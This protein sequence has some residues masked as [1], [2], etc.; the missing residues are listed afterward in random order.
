MSAPNVL[1]RYSWVLT[2]SGEMTGPPSAEYV[3]ALVLQ[4]VSLSVALTGTAPGVKQECR[5]EPM[6]SLGLVSP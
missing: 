1:P 6:L 4:Q 3:R 2:I 5:V